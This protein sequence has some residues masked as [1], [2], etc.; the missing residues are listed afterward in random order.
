MKKEGNRVKDR[1]MMKWQ[2]FVS[3]IEQKQAIDEVLAEWDKVEKPILDEWQYEQI[4]KAVME[5]FLTQERIEL[6]YYER[7]RL[8]VQNGV[9]EK[10]NEAYRILVFVTGNKKRKTISFDAVIEVK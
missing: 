9:I 4:S 2:P 7:G 3:M 8:I 6:I 1:G 10:I 5:S